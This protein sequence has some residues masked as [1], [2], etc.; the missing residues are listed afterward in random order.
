MPKASL[1]FF[2]ATPDVVSI[3]RL[4]ETFRSVAA[5][6]GDFE[7]TFLVND[8]DGALGVEGRVPVW[9]AEAEQLRGL[10]RPLKIV[11]SRYVELGDFDTLDRMLADAPNASETILV[12]LPGGARFV[13]DAL[14]VVADVLDKE[15]SI[16][17]L[18]G[19]GA[20]FGPAGVMTSLGF[21][22]A[23]GTWDMIG[24]VADDTRDQRSLSGGLFWRADLWH[25]LGRMDQ[26]LVYTGYLDFRSKAAVHA[27]IGQIEAMLVDDPSGSLTTE[28]TGRQQ[29]E[30][31]RVRLRAARRQARLHE[32]MLDE[33]ADFAELRPPVIIAYDAIKE[34]WQRRNPTEYLDPLGRA[35]IVSGYTGLVG[36]FPDAGLPRRFRWTNS[37]RATFSVM[38]ER[39]RYHV[40]MALRNPSLDQTVTVD[41][42]GETI[43]TMRPTSASLHDCF[44]LDLTCEFQQGLNEVRLAVDVMLTDGVA[45][46]L[47]LVVE[48]V[49]IVSAPL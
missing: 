39:G 18:E 26:S 35:V 47:G 13:P 7:L 38:A 33:G 29:A 32:R 46:P 19:L 48:S 25:C 15:P 20:T 21:G 17:I 27:Q 2:V 8:P 41:L 45:Q 4:D 28:D 42:N 30:I 34:A 5:Q 49:D 3:D 1:H 40:A 36:P 37:R 31:V 11:V 14:L 6:Q 10:G 44:E 24:A 43:F 12:P 16:A 9:R 23:G 22:P